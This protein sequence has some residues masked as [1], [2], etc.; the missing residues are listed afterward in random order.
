MTGTLLAFLLAVAPHAREGDAQAFTSLVDVASGA[1]IADGRYVQRVEGGL[2]HIES[3]NDFP[4]GRVIVERAVLRLEPELRQESW[5]W[6]E[7]KNGA[8]VRQYEVDFRAGHA[9]ATRVDQH[10]RW[11]EDLDV[12]PGK[13]FAGIAFVAVIK[14]LRTELA[15]GEKID[16]K[17]VAFTP[18]PRLA[19]VSITRGR[20]E[21]V[22]MAGRTIAADPYTIHPEIPAIAKLFVTAPDQRV[23]LYGTGPAAFL[24]YEG[25]L[26]E[27]KDPR[28]RVDT[29]PSRAANAARAPERKR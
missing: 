25:P 20:P 15:P 24:R 29:I 8:L 12:A 7:R 17:A 28:I 4:D 11:K 6:T 23:W 14:A 3:R 10:K 26:V 1:T 13:T 9:V 27:P 2:L 16:L 5:D 19:P 18:K 21:Q 22:T